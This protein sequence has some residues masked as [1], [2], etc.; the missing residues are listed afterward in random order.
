MSHKLHRPEAL[1]SLIRDMVTKAGWSEAEAQETADHLVLA[2]L[3]GHDSHGVGMIPLYF[4]SL[5]DGNLKPESK[6]VTRVE[7]APFLIVD[8]NIA[9]GQPNARNAVDRAAAMAGQTGV[10]IVN[11]LDSHHIGRI[12]HYAEVAAAAGLISFFWVN[13]AG[14]PPIV[15]PFA[16][17]EARFGTNPHAIG[18]PVPGGEP[19][20]L[21][22]A[23]SRMA[24]GKARVALNKGEQ[25]PPGYIIDGE[26]RPTTDP[27]HVFASPD[28]PLGALLPFGDHKG[29]GL[30]LIAELLSAGL[31]GAARIDQKPQKSWIINSL[32][33]VLIDPARL[34]P[35]ADLR[36]SRIDSYL[37]FVRAARPQDPANPVL[38]PGD[39]ER[40][41]RI[42]RGAAGIPLDDETWSQIRAA[43]ARHGIDADS[44]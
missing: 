28:H 25:V 17:K 41:V 20:I 19:L 12:G 31:M 39:K 21:D 7:A 3:S 1:R 6:G 8:G 35:D 14:R 32:F 34:E 13:V 38:A 30:S 11:L 42:E 24:H 36:R 4:Q 44:Y 15:A 5:A 10:A 2:N 22:F 29:A 40:R 23:T 26:G 9:L 43:A 33:G 18:I 27:A 37:A 16:A